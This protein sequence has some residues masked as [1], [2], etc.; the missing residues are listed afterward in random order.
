MSAGSTI[1]RELAMIRS[2][3]RYGIDGVDGDLLQREL[4]LLIIQVREFVAEDALRRRKRRRH[5]REPALRAEPAS[6][7]S[8]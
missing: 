8:S 5:A 2:D 7:T 3:P 1:E 6:R 4:E